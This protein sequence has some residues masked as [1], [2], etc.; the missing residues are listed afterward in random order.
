MSTQWEHDFTKLAQ[1]FDLNSEAVLK[2]LL[3]AEEVIADGFQENFFNQVDETGKPWPPRKDNKPHPLLI[4]TGKMFA[5][6]TN[7]RSPNHFSDIEASTDRVTL[8]TG[9]SDAAVPYYKYH[10][11]DE[12]RTKIP[13]RRVIYVTVQQANRASERFADVVEDSWQ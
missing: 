13:R 12:P 8:V 1:A 10:H 11:S 5:A 2:G 3:A 4:K 6:A 9:I 7:T